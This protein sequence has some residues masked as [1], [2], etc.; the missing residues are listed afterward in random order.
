MN[1]YEQKIKGVFLI[2][3]TPFQD[4]RGV[5]RRHFCNEEFAEHKIVTNISQCNVSENLFA[6]T[7][8]GF[9]YQDAP[10]AEG[11]TMSCFRGSMYDIV[12]DLRPASPT[13][14]EW[15]SFELSEENRRTI[16][17][18]PGCANAFMTLED[19]TLIHYYCSNA[20]H[21]SAEHGIRFND[22]SFS[23]DWPYQPAVISDRDVNHP[24]YQKIQK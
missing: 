12:V 3:P 13:Y 5:F 19:K 1:F 8:R 15:I 23:F 17:I 11:K 9:H 22:P 4:E 20:Y 21:P 7:L 10:F 18:P 6:R 24:D 16:H 14:M 2:E